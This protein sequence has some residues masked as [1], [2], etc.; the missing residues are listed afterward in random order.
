M[1]KYRVVKQIP[2]LD[3]LKPG[4]VVEQEADGVYRVVIDGVKYDIKPVEGNINFEYCGDPEDEPILGSL[5]PVVPKTPD[6]NATRAALRIVGDDDKTETP[7]LSDDFLVE[8]RA[9]ITEFL[10]YLLSYIENMKP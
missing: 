9:V 8:N 2:G 4:M 1:R 10:K 7:K 3:L 5:A 6:V